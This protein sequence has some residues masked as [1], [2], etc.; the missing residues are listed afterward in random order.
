MLRQ[1]IKLELVRRHMTQTELAVQLGIGYKQLNAYLN[2]KRNSLAI[3]DALTVWL[4]DKPVRHH[5][6]KPR[7]ARTCARN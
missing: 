7:R 2:G 6:S 4:S 3:E 1:K 5:G